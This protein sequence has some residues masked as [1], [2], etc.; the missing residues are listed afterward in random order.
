[1]KRF[2]VTSDVARKA[3][4]A[5]HK[6]Y[7]QKE[8]QNREVSYDEI[9]ELI[10]TDNHLDDE[11]Q[12]EISENVKILSNELYKNFITI[13][14]EACKGFRIAIGIDDDGELYA[15]TVTHGTIDTNAFYYEDAESFIEDEDTGIEQIRAWFNDVFIDEVIYIINYNCVE[16]PE[17]WIAA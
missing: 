2:M 1:M 8:M 15:A 14:N 10:N 11:K 6:V 7:F 4:L 12:F 13:V 3:A 17:N 16:L 5:G 9:I